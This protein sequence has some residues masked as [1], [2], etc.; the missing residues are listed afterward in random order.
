[1][2][3]QRSSSVGTVDHARKPDRLEACDATMKF[4]TLR[5]EVIG[6][7]RETFGNCRGGRFLDTFYAREE[8][9]SCFDLCLLIIIEAKIFWIC[10]QTNAASRALGVG[11]L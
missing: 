7:Y 5:K 3:R 2:G 6:R 1:M 8:A 10:R 11:I 9:T 4:R